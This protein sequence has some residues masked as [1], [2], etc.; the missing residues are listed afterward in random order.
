MKQIIGE[1]YRI[2]KCAYYN[3]YNKNPNGQK[4]KQIFQG[5]DIYE[6]QYQLHEYNAI[7]SFARFCTTKD[8]IIN[9]GI[10]E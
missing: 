2:I 7:A 10:G 1:K 5:L 9:C 6:V 3:G 8:T 4:I